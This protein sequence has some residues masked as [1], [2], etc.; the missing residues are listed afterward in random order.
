MPSAVCCRMR[1]HPGFDFE[2]S[3]AFGAL[4]RRVTTLP[5][6]VPGLEP[7]G[8][9]LLWIVCLEA[10]LGPVVQ[11]PF[12]G[13]SDCFFGFPIGAPPALFTTDCLVPRFEIK[14]FLDASAT[15]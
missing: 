8:A 1:P 6:V 10:R 12:P 13:T 9:M 3:C 11:R 5:R 7:G 14:L 2:A 4:L 15:V